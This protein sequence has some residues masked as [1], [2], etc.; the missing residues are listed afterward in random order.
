[1]ARSRATP[2]QRR[3]IEAADARRRHQ[4]RTH[5]GRAQRRRRRAQ[6]RQRAHRQHRLRGALRR[7]RRQRRGHRSGLDGQQRVHGAPHEPCP[8]HYCCLSSLMPLSSNGADSEV[9]GAAGSAGASN[10]SAKRDAKRTSAT[11]AAAAADATVAPPELTAAAR[12]GAMRCLFDTLPSSATSA[13]AAAAAA[14]ATPTTARTRCKR[15]CKGAAVLP[16]TTTGNKAASATGGTCVFGCI[17]QS[18]RVQCLPHRPLHFFAISSLLSRPNAQAYSYLFDNATNIPLRPIPAVRPQ[19]DGTPHAGPRA[20]EITAHPPL[21]PPTYT[22]ITRPIPVALL[23]TVT[24]QSTALHATRSST[25]HPAQAPR[26][27][28]KDNK[29]FATT[30]TAAS[31]EPSQYPS[32]VN[33]SDASM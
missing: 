17:T 26:S 25:S 27:I 2:Q 16:V 15:R 5:R 8:T 18:T 3:R 24:N 10:S 1:M 22:Q 11:A 4:I 28:S 29:S 19:Y 12:G 6:R 23:V 7:Q 33:S 20:L 32:P 14:A 9:T 21:T 13:A 31:K 30:R